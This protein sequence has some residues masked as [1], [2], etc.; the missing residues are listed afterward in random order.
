[1][2]LFDIFLLRSR[3]VLNTGETPERRATQGSQHL[4]R[5]DRRREGPPVRH[6][7]RAHRVDLRPL[8]V[9]LQLGRQLL[10]PWLLPALCS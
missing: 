3:G 5:R 6:T 8:R 1:M 4:V 10:L 9:V 7:T 2:R